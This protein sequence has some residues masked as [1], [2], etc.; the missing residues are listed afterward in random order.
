MSEQLT[1]INLDVE[2][3]A[4][5]PAEIN[6]DLPKKDWEGFISCWSVV[7]DKNTACSWAKGD[8]VS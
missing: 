6:S 7:E 1:T 2:M 4:I 5:P 8:L 3:L